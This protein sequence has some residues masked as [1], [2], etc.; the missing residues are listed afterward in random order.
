M[1]AADEPGFDRSRSPAGDRNPWLIAVVIAFASFME[2]LDISIAN[3]ALRHIAG[4]LA[5]GVDESTWILTSYLIA[6]AV[7]LPISG[8]LANAIGRKRFY[9]I[10]VGV[11]TV[12]SILCGLA[13][14]LGW[15]IVF[16]V[17]QGL[18]GGGMVPI[19]QAILADC[20]PPRQRGQAFG[21]FGIAVVVA[22]TIGPTLGGWLTDNY[23]WHWIFFINGPVGVLSLMLVAWLLIEP[24]VLERERRER[25]AGGLHLDWVGFILVVLFFGGLE[26]VLDKGEREDWFQSNFI[27]TFAT[28]SAIG[29]ILLIPWEL[30]RKQP[31]VDIRLFARRQFGTCCL[32]MVA[33]FAVLLGATQQLPQLLQTTFGYDATF[34]GLVLLPA[35]LVMACMM[36]IA[37]SLSA[38]IQPKYLI[39]FGML[40]VAFGMW[41]TAGFTADANFSFFAWSR[42]LQTIGLPFLFIPI[43]SASYANLPPNKTNDAAALI[44]VARNLG[45]SIGVSVATAALASSAQRHQSY[46]TSNLFPSSVP[47]QE[48][49][50]RATAELVA[51]GIPPAE[52]QRQAYELIGQ[53]VA[54]QATVMSYIDIFTT[55]AMVAAL[56]AP[57]ALLVLQR[58]ELG[59]AQ[60]AAG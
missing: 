57:V 20:F 19:G 45:G 42:L 58:V 16:R 39:A 28:I 53:T 4:S 14:S 41:H 51:R 34:A 1:S 49:L 10:C 29:L 26:V 43:T 38:I 21:I 56:M 5:A 22:P 55:F 24:E 2:V 33:T 27:I 11:F 46:L 23:S 60:P 31:I 50:S 52:A 7:V 17:L 12:S 9:M 47:F 35:G 54:G 36:P 32:L 18:G 15:L 48:A 59:R 40:S 44:N 25:L 3:V 8:W 6:N 30:T 13:W 37:G